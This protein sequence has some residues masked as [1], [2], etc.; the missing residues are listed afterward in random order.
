MPP[1]FTESPSS[2]RHHFLCG[3]ARNPMKTRRS[4]PGIPALLLAGS[5]IA[6][7]VSADPLPNAWQITDNSA[8]S[9]LSYTNILNAD[10]RT[11][12]SNSGFDFSVNARFVTNYGT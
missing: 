4:L 10:R 7:L 3:N 1:G 11:A 5:L 9:G 8:G 12:A 2:E 6:Q